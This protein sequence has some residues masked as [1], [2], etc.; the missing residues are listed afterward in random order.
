MTETPATRDYA[1]LRDL[2]EFATRPLSS[3][4]AGSYRFIA[5]DVETACSDAA[6]ICQ[7]GIA[8]VSPDDT[9]ETWASHVNPRTH[10]SPFNIRIHGIEPEHV[11]DA[12]CF[13]EAIAL[14]EPLL[15]RHHIIQHS[16][17][18]RRAIS[19]AYAV[20]GREAPPWT[21]GDSVRIAR[22]AWPEFI[23]NGGHGLANLK[24]RLDLRFDHH[25]AG[26]DA[27]AAAEVVL[28][29]ER[30]TREVFEALLG[31]TPKTRKAAGA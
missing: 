22:R 5:L 4:P 21:W 29:A 15:A 3:V 7:I 17:F 23:G 1:G 24:Q 27:R 13:D 28:R 2:T 9:I 26:E 25:D 8:C 18:D 6:S 12:P 16:S 31:P 20:L 14:L 11:V 19:G 30:R 10:F